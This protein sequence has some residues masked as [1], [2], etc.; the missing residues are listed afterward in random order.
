MPSH[1]KCCTCHTKSPSQN[2]R[3]DAPKCNP[4]QEISALTSEHLWWTCLVYC[5][6]HAKC[7]FT[8]PL[9]MSFWT[10]Y[11]SS[12]FA[13]F[14]QGAQSLAPATRNDIWTSKSVPY[15]SVFCTF[16]FDTRFAPQRSALFDMSTSK[17]APKMRCFVQ[18]DLEMCIAP[19]RRTLFQHINF[20]KWSGTVSFWHFW[21]RNVL[22]ATTA[23]TFSTSPF[24]KVLR[25]WRA[26]YLLTSKCASRHIGVQFFISHLARWLCTPL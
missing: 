15:P 20:Q 13:H 12:D 17:S 23:G 9:Q 21:L 4:C 5:G 7:I 14:W 11:K 1:T 6:C 16:D 2:W 19:Q 10:C 8:D 22:L 18:F 24:L 26:L 3:S 25:S